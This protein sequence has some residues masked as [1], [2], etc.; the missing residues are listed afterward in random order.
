[1]NSPPKLLTCATSIAV[2]FV[3]TAWGGDH[4][5]YPIA[6]RVLRT[7][8]ISTKADGTRTTTTCTDT[9]S[10]EITCDS[11]EVSAGR[12]TELVSFVNA[13]D[14]KLYMISCV[15]GA[16]SR[17]LSGMGQ[18]MQ[19]NAGLDTVS[20]CAVPPG[21]YKARWDKGRLKVVREKDG[22]S[23]ETT[24]VILSS[25]P[26]PSATSPPPSESKMTLLLLSSVPPGADIEMDGT[27]V[28]NTPS[29]IPVPL[30]EHSIRIEKSGYKP[31][32]RK[33]STVGGEVTIAAELEARTK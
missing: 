21:T 10:D 5:E 12:H 24:F 27:F 16:G 2:L 7:D 32:E 3:A 18:S 19:A 25:G 20:G 17:F 9:G 22:K 30:G 13:G 1:M 23:K 6:L 26:M 14:G 8:A 4:K 28:G 29:S 11:K 15:L 33:V 31:W